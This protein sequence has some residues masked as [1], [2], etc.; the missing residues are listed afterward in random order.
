MVEDDSMPPLSLGDLRS[1]EQLIKDLYIDLRQRVNAWASITFQTPQARMGYIG[2]HLTSIVTGYPGGRSG[3]RGYDLVL[4]DNRHAEIKTCYR[5]DQLG[6]CSECGCSISAIEIACPR[7]ASHHIERKDDS[8]WLIGPQNID[9][10]SQIADPS[11]YYFVLFEFV[12]IADPREIAASIWQV[13]SISPGFL[14][15]MID[16]WFNIRMHSTSKVPLNIWPHRFKRDLM[17]GKL[18]YR[19][20]VTDD[21]VTTRI[22]PG[23]DEPI[24]HSIE[25]LT[26]QLR[27]D[28]LR[29]NKNPGVT[30][31]ISSYSQKIGI[32]NHD[33]LNSM[34]REISLIHERNESGRA[35]QLQ[36]DELA[37][38]IYFPRLVSVLKEIPDRLKVLEP[39]QVL[40]RI[41]ESIGP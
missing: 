27:T 15:S 14:L 2:Q 35:S 34:V 36:L 11:F 33:D 28:L 17:G 9:E 4:P 12:N 6:K 40:F 10:L 30:H 26:T 41:K 23:R 32:G 38:Y 39:I 18:I 7:C 37:S 19:S 31:A 8:K 20:I 29:E 24:Q 22:F 13:D 16:Y 5:V 25:P 1:S 3:A 21:S